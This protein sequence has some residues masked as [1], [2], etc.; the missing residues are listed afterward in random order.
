MQAPRMHI[1][2]VITVIPAL[3]DGS[4]APEPSLFKRFATQWF[5][6]MV[7]PLIGGIQDPSEAGVHYLLLEACVAFLSWDSLFPV[8]P[9]G[10]HALQLISYLVRT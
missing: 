5:P 8:P 6:A 1:M 4:P 10:E 7:D 2:Y 9:R 3:Q